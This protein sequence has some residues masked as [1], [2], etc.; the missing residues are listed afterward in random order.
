LHRSLPPEASNR[1]LRVESAEP[2]IPVASETGSG[3]VVSLSKMARNL[4]ALGNSDGALDFYRTI[5]IQYPDSPY[6]DLARQRIKSFGARFPLPEQ[7]TAT[8]GGHRSTA[9]SYVETSARSSADRIAN[10]STTRRQR[11]YRAYLHT[12]E[13]WG[14]YAVGPLGG[15]TVFVHG[16][17]RS[18]GTHVN[19]YWRSPPH[20]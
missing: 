13:P 2:A 14:S 18:D 4:E 20:R 3:R 10:P 5:M 8:G 9:T 1:S 17:D 19:S 15:R 6:A 16:Y 12:P 11:N 7:Y